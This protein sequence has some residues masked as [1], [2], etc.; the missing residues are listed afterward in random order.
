MNRP[1]PS[2]LGKVARRRTATGAQA[3]P[4]GPAR[5]SS[6]QAASTPA[7][8]PGALT[9]NIE[10]VTDEGRI[11][12]EVQSALA[13]KVAA[14]VLEL[15]EA[16]KFDGTKF[17]RAGYLRGQPPTPRFLEGGLLSPFLL[18]EE[19]RRLTTAADVGLPVL[20]DWER[21]DQSGL[22]HIR[23][24]VS[25]A[26]DIAGQGGVL[27]DFVIALET[28]TE[29]DAGGGFSPQ[30]TGFPV[31]GRVVSGMDVVDAIAGRSRGRGTYVAFLNG[32]ILDEPVRIQRVIRTQPLGE[33]GA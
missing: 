30:N 4:A 33:S 25:L 23:G 10:L 2:G 7:A 6:G 11:E 24:A 27:P 19:G 31:F 3:A 16:K 28:V 26:R 1:T 20:S 21:T 18:G 5:S 14:W 8:S 32:Q 12:I 15:V 22:R 13:P 9:A 29:L 17:F